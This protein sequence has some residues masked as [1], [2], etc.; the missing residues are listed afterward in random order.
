MP[1]VNVNLS[2]ALNT[3]ILTRWGTIAAW[4]QWVKDKS[5]LEIAEAEARQ[6]DA[7]AEAQRQAARAA[8]EVAN[9]AL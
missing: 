8:A 7:D 6:I 9:A 5:K 2:D 4:K 3:K 1:D